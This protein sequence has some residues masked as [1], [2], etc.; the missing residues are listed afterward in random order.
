MPSNGERRRVLVA[1]GTADASR[2]L[3]VFTQEPLHGWEAVPADSF[4]EARFVLQH[5][6]CDLLLVDEA[7]YDQQGPDGLSW[8]ARQREVPLVFLGGPAPDKVT[9]AYEDGANV[10]LPRG[11]ALSNPRLMAAALER[12]TELTCLRRGRERAAEAVHHCRRQI[13]RLVGLLW[14]TAP[15]NTENQWLTHRHMLERLQE[16]VARTERHGTPLTVVLGE[17]QAAPGDDAPP[18]D[19]ATLEPLTTLRI[20]RAKR[21]CD[22]A[23]HYGM[24]GFMLLLVQTPQTGAVTCCRRLQ[25]L[26][27]ETPPAAN[28]GPRGPIRAYFGVASYAPEASN[29]RSLLSRAEERLEK[30]RT[31]EPERVVAG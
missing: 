25:K 23:G 10:W 6:A 26:L 20:A 5:N 7:L 11:V 3:S 2:L 19:A 30:A 12:A 18:A 1:T 8:L 9:R 14:R 24:H 27:E 22:V 29:P 4:E 31:A 13:D 28:A 21:R 15:M 17:L 16:E